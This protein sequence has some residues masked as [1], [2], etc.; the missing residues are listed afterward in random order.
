MTGRQGTDG[1]ARPVGY[2]AEPMRA[3][4]STLCVFGL[5]ACSSEGDELDPAPDTGVNDGDT[6]TGAPDGG[7]GADTGTPQPD[8]GVQVTDSGVVDPPGELTLPPIQTGANGESAPVSFDLPAG[9]VSFMLTVE[10]PQD[11][12]MIVK[13]LTGPSGVLVTDDESNVSQIERFLLG[14]FAA[15]FKSPNRV[16]QDIGI[17]AALFPNNPG[18]SVSSGSYQ[19][20]MSAIR[21]QGQNGNPY[22]GTLTGKVLYRTEALASGHL[23]VHLYFSGAGNV[24]A[25]TAPSDPLVQGA[26]QKVSSVY[27]QANITLGAVTYHDVDASFRNISGIDGSS[28]Q[29]E[30]LFRLS[31]GNGAGLHY[32]FVD[33][34]EGGLPGGMVAGIAG[35]LPGPA[36]RPGT[37]NSGVAVALGAVNGDAQILGHV[38]AH[39]GGHWLGLFHTAEFT[40]T[41]DQLSDT[42]G[43]QNAGQNY[44]MFP[45]VGGGTMM[46]PSQG[47]VVRH[48]GEVVG[49]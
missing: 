19:L 7:A 1:A 11:V 36:L 23:D 32:F 2:R 8:S 6:G 41:Q 44:L 16:V 5:L 20:V 28:D 33:R 42:P 17:A 9:V 35:G 3:L 39:E 13:R 45:A 40:G 30:R 22:Q 29:L 38:M 49:G 34:F 26:L 15:Q 43:D 24:T 46:S 48:H 47:T 21:I 37:N 14:P 18:V 10:G 31:D 4:I 25:A 27:A 12:T